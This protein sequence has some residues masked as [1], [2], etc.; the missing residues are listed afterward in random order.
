MNF[1]EMWP[2]SHLL[3]NSEEA[4]HMYDNG[5]SE[6]TAVCGKEVPHG[7]WVCVWNH[8]LPKLDPNGTVPT[9]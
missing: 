9:G 1:D 5:A 2:S 8:Y 6:S 4:T 7:Y 3:L